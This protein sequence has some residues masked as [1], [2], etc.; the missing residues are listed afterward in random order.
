VPASAA[1]HRQALCLLA[2]VLASCAAPL[3]RGDEI[4][5]CG[6]LFPT[7]T[8]VVLWSDPD[9]YDAY[10]E[11]NWFPETAPAPPRKRYG[12][13]RGRPS[14]GWT[15]PDLQ[16]AVDLF[17]IHYDVC[18]TSRQC[19]KVL[20]DVRCL[21]VHFLL[22]VDGTIYQTLDLQER[23]WHAS[24]TN[25]RA[26]GVEIAQIGAYPAPGHPVLRSW[27]EQDAGGPRVRFPPW[28]KETGIRIPDFVARPARAEL[29]HGEVH[30]KAYW[31]YDFTPEQ[32]RALAHLTAALVTH[33]P[34]IEL[35]VPRDGDGKV[36]GGLLPGGASPEFHGLVGHWHVNPGKQDPGP[37][38]DWDALLAMAARIL[39]AREVDG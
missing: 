34:R 24:A 2:G 18:G 3:R 10:R 16:Q 6:Q 4:S 27:H 30:G 20:H 29:V 36:V 1:P 28:M 35:A 38:F 9:G 14:G 11:G 7:G 19:F 15:L 8:R 26:V 37:A 33:L 21:S 23:A 25:D 13:R 17:V 31:Q 5:I 22:D 32:Y 12:G 39:L